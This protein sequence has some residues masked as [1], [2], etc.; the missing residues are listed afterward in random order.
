MCGREKQQNEIINISHDKNIHMQ[1][2]RQSIPQIKV[3]KMSRLLNI[4]QGNVE[5]NIE[6]SCFNSTYSKSR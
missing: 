3:I 2:Y 1:H 5:Q 6:P 4:A